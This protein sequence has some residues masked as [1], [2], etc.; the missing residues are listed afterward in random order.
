MP[1]RTECPI[2]GRWIARA[3]YHEVEGRLAVWRDE[4]PAP[5]DPSVLPLGL[6]F[7]LAAGSD[8]AQ[9]DLLSLLT[10]LQPWPEN[11]CGHPFL[12][13]FCRTPDH[14]I[15]PPEHE[16]TVE[17]TL[18]INSSKGRDEFLL[19]G[20]DFGSP[21]YQVLVN[22]KDWQVEL[23]L[24]NRGARMWS[25]VPLSRHTLD[26]EGFVRKVRP[27]VQGFQLFERL[28]G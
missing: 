13:Q 1:S 15:A 4:V 20:I 14:R 5:L 11:A 22:G 19:P 7:E 2:F 16:I 27:A 3:A 9:G 26:R 23:C 24:S 28:P 6:L 12:G 25:N 8:P 10:I 21:V 17:F 18:A